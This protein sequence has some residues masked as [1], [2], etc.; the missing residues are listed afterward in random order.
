MYFKIPVFNPFGAELGMFRDNSLNI[1]TSDAL[2]PCITRSSAAVVLTAQ[3]KQVLVFLG[4]GFQWPGSSWCWEMVE[5]ANMILF[6]KIT[7]A[8]QGWSAPIYFAADKITFELTP[9]SGTYVDVY[10]AEKEVKKE[11]KWPQSILLWP[12]VTLDENF[13][14]II[15]MIL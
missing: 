9:Y 7:S 13:P 8:E 4:G 5:N 10:T 6:P 3:D 2:A 14:I 12:R 1:I 11:W 15:F